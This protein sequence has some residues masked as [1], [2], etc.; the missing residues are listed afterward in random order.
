MKKVLLI[1]PAWKASVGRCLFL[2]KLLQPDFQLFLAVFHEIERF[3]SIYYLPSAEKPFKSFHDL[4]LGARWLC[5]GNCDV[6]GSAGVNFGPLVRV[7]SGEVVPELT[8]FVS[9]AGTQE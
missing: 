5:S 8:G 4:L 7:V 9:T 3:A 6:E 1:D 2:R